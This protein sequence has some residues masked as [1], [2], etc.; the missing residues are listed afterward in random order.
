[1]VAETIATTDNSKF[2]TIRDFENEL[3][4]GQRGISGIGSKGKKHNNIT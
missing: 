4:D 2:V 3:R 1:M